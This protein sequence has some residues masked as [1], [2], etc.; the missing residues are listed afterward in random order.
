MVRRIARAALIA[1][2]LALAVA[3]ASF[4]AKTDPGNAIDRAFVREMVPS[5][6]IALE[7]AQLAVDQADH[8]QLQDMARSIV[9]D[10]TLEARR[11]QRVADALGVNPGDADA[12]DQRV[13]ARDARTMG[14]TVAQ[15]GMSTDPG[16]LDGA[17]PFDVAFIDATIVVD[18]GAIRMARV[19]L[20]EGVNVRLR[21]IARS[22]AADATAQVR[23]LSVW[24]KA[25]YAGP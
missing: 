20:D 10:N 1:V 12:L 8:Q 3:P 18:R 25:W 17:S 2:A 24:R 22:I 13:M 6:Q 14:L 9:A 19:E 15:M 16:A 5:Q 21:T 11:M 4:A 7:M 23:R